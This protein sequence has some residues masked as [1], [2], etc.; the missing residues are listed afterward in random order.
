[1]LLLMI[2]TEKQMGEIHSVIFT[3]GAQSMTLCVKHNWVGT[4]TTTM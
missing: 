4:D 3:E 1:M 2:D